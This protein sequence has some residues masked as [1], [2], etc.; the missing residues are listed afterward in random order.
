[1]PIEV[2]FRQL[3]RAQE[4]AKEASEE[5]PDT[6]LCRAVYNNLKATGLFK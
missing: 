5:I 6:T 3:R 4:L 2:L 1:M